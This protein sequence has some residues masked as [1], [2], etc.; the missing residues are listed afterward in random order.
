MSLF[1][2]GPFCGHCMDQPCICNRPYI[3]KDYLLPIYFDMEFTGLHQNTT[4][5]SIGCVSESG[6]IFYAE[7]LDYDE[8]QVDEWIRDNV[9]KN[10]RFGGDQESFCADERPSSLYN[11]QMS[12]YKGLIAVELEKWLKT[13]YRI[14]TRKI[15]MHS[16]CL[17]YDWMLFVNLISST[18]YAIDLQDYINYIPID[19]STMLLA[20]GM[21]PD[22]NREKFAEITSQVPVTIP[23]HNALWDAHMIKECFEKIEKSRQI[24]HSSVRIFGEEIPIAEVKYHHKQK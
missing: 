22:I 14:S 18:G 24:S 8:S 21:D 11:V 10:L 16:D 9:I 23:K 4:P 15:R 2:T 6:S 17:A 5:I 13:E 19:L 12:S 20:A 3:Y 7:F 1:E